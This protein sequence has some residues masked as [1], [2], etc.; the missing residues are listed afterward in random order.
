MKSWLPVMVAKRCPP[1][2]W[3]IV[4]AIWLSIVMSFWVVVFLVEPFIAALSAL[5]ERRGD[6]G[7]KFSVRVAI[8][9][10]VMLV[11][12]A[13]GVI[14]HLVLFSAG[15]CGCTYSVGCHSRCYSNAVLVFYNQYPIFKCYIGVGYLSLFQP[16]IKSFWLLGLSKEL[17][18]QYLTHLYNISS[19]NSICFKYKHL[20]L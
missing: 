2:C 20:W 16:L 8:V 15:S 1:I 12:W 7:E 9:V 10:L 18:N 14:E 11:P 13:V 5:F 4:F 3:S 19:C 6:A 17:Y